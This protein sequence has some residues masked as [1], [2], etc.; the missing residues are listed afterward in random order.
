MLEM[1][2]EET[3]RPFPATISFPLASDRDIDTPAMRGADLG[4]YRIATLS[5]H[6]G[7]EAFWGVGIICRRLLR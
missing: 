5:R 7:S 6:L 4:Q 2:L 1:N 3:L